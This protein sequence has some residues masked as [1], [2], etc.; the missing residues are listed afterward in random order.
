[1][2]RIQTRG[3]DEVVGNL[4]TVSNIE[5]HD[6]FQL[7]RIEELGAKLGQGGR[8]GGD[9]GGGCRDRLGVP[10]IEALRHRRRSRDSDLFKLELQKHI[11]EH[12]PRIYSGNTC[13]KH[14]GAIGPLLASV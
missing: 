13:R 1:M 7:L 8:K 14:C 10:G 3:D 11:P 5:D 4:E 12:I 9:V 6:L 2:A